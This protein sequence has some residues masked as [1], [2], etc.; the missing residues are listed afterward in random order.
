M[1]KTARLTVDEF[2]EEY[3]KLPDSW[4]Y[5]LKNG[6]VVTMSPDAAPYH[7]ELQFVVLWLL[8]IATETREG[9]FIYG[10]T[11]VQLVED[12]L[13][14][15]PDVTVVTSADKVKRLGTKLVGAPSLV[16]EIVSPN[17]PNIDLIEKRDLYTNRGVRE[18][19]FLDSR[20]HEALFLCRSLARYREFRM[21][22]GIF[23]SRAIKGL[24]VDVA[25]LF[26]LDR[27]QLRKAAGL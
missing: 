7:G 12:S 9:V 25:A 17:K 23:Q 27:K 2:I 1:P 11:N 26:D 19:W 4:R 13:G 10:P 22:Q 8:G 24:K 6:E 21:A 18:I 3:S 14:K 16:V 15:G 20:R 5:E